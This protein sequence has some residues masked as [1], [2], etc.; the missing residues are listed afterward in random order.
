MALDNPKLPYHRF[1]V[2]NIK[3]IRA[4]DD[5]TIELETVNPLPKITYSFG[6]VIFGNAFRVVPKHVWEKVDP[7]TFENYPPVTIGPYKLKDTDPN[8]F[9]FLWEKRDDELWAPAVYALTNDGERATHRDPGQHTSGPESL[10]Y[11][12]QP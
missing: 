2:N 5:E 9:C 4:V 3:D 1:I 12:L 11:P 8:G 6:S 10:F 7:L